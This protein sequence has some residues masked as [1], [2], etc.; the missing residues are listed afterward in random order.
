MTNKY[1]RTIKKGG[2][3][4][5]VDVY[6]VLDAF[7]V[8]CPALQHLIKKALCVGIRG[9]K[10]EAQDLEDILDS[11]NRAI[12]LFND[13]NS[14]ENEQSLEDLIADNLCKSPIDVALYN[15]QTGVEDD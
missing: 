13:R 14:T 11:V 6:D 8:K 2:K 3:Q 9:H 15:I 10:N 5:V 1:N 4:V 7:D 12:E